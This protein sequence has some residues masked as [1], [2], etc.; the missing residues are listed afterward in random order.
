V[1]GAFVDLN[2]ASAQGVIGGSSLLKT[3]PP[4]P[5]LRL[6]IRGY[7]VQTP[8]RFVPGAPGAAMIGA[9]GWSEF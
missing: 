2:L 5:A 3:K 9:L 8:V 6:P 7:C 1:W 4:S